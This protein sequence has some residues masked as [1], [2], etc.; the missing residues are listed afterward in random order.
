MLLFAGGVKSYSY[1]LKFYNFACNLHKYDNK[2]LNNFE[3]IPGIVA[4]YSVVTPDGVLDYELIRFNEYTP[5]RDLFGIP[6]DYERVT[7]D[8]FIE[9]MTGGNEPPPPPQEGN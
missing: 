5:N 2:Y 9:T 4:K 7:I 6:S 1:G 8:Q 3:G